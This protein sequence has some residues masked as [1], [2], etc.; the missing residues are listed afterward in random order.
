MLIMLR[1]FFVELPHQLDHIAKLL[2]Q[3]L[4]AEAAD[5]VHKTSGSAAYC[6]TPLLR[7]IAKQFE[8]TLRGN[9][10]QAIADSHEKFKEEIKELLTLEKKIIASLKKAPS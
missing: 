6:G 3:N 5:V 1:K 10:E 8:T 9:N 2:S 4:W 7:V